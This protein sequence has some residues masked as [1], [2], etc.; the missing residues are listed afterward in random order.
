MPRTLPALL[1]G[2]SL[3]PVAATADEFVQC[4]D[5]GCKSQTAFSLDNEQWASIA[6]LFSPQSS[7]D[8][9]S[10][11]QAIRAAI[12]L[13]EKYGGNITGTH[14]DKGGNYP[15][16]DIAMQMDC[17]DESTNTHQYLTALHRRN[18]LRWHQVEERAHRIVWFFD[19]WTAVISEQDSQQKYAVDSWYRDNGELP[20]LQKLED[21]R[22]KKDF[23]ASLNPELAETS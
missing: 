23:P 1:L 18:L 11:K 22:H 21:W 13:I 4:Y 5:F 8:V 20:L 19:H 17:I 2:L 7:F 3:L 9:D 14:L 12:A 15:G 6:A 10:E 16:S